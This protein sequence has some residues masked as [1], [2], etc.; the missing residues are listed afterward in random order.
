[1]KKNVSFMIA[2]SLLL[3]LGACDNQMDDAKPIICWD[4]PELIL[5]FAVDYTT[6]TFLHGFMQPLPGRVD[7]FA[8]VADYKSPGDFGSITWTEKNTD[9]KI[10]SGTIIWMGKGQQTFP[11]WPN[12]K[13]AS[14]DRIEQPVAMPPLITLTNGTEWDQPVPE[15]SAYVPVWNAISSLESVYR[16]LTWNPKAPVYIYLYQPSVGVGNPKDWYWLV[17]MHYLCEPRE[18]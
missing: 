4:E 2:L 3:G 7:S 15:Q 16:C 6:N 18:R 14:Y 11:E 1:M 13:A 17:F 9:K 12:N 5:G 10:F 8:L